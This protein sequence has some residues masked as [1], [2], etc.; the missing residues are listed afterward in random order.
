MEWPEA[1]AFMVSFACLVAFAGW[2][3][4]LAA[5]MRGNDGN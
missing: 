1:I 2:V 4:Y 3:F 5:K